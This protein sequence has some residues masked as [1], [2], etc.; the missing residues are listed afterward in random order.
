ME[1]LELGVPA[2]AVSLVGRDHFDF[3]SAAVFTA[4]WSRGLNVDWIVVIPEPRDLRELIDCLIVAEWSLRDVDTAKRSIEVL[5]CST[6]P[7]TVSPRIIPVCATKLP[8]VGEL[9]RVSWFILT[10]PS[11][12]SEGPCTEHG[13]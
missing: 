11:N 5:V 13:R 9:V 2:I 4:F 7:A 8:I 12:H 1:D 3:A 10:L 6:S